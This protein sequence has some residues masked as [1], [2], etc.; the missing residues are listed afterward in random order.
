[1]NRHEIEDL[2]Q[3]VVDLEPRAIEPKRL[4]TEEAVDRLVDSWI[5]CLGDFGIAEARRAVIKHQNTSRY[6]VSASDIRYQCFQTRRSRPEV[7]WMYG[8]A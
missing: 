8:E 5:E 6:P 2:I 4:A 7:A 3:F 1:M